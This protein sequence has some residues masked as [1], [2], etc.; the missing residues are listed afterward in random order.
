M[1]SS[2]SA[3]PPPADPPLAP[4][5]DLRKPEAIAALPAEWPEPPDTTAPHARASTLETFDCGARYGKLRA[6][7]VALAE[8][9]EACRRAAARAKALRELAG[10]LREPGVNVQG[11][12]VTRDG[13]LR[14]EL[15]RLVVLCARLKG[16]VE[17]EGGVGDWGGGDGEDGMVTEEDMGMGIGRGMGKRVRA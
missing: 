16:K 1:S 17:A 2:A 10:G 11:S 15:E 4:T 6:R 8:K 12:L 13:E 3:A 5:A 9:R 7:L 14:R